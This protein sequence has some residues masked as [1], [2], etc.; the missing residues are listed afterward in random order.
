M[1]FIITGIKMYMY[2]LII[3]YGF[4]FLLLVGGEPVSISGGD[5]K[6][7]SLCLGYCCG[8]G[9]FTDLFLWYRNIR[10]SLRG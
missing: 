1:P 3:E 7:D 2:Q 9:N 6:A 4:Y 10:R 8:R 5:S